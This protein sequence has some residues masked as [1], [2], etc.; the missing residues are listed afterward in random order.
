MDPYY[1]MLDDPL[2][3]LYSDWGQ[4]LL[5]ALAKEN[6][7]IP[8][9][10]MTRID[11]LK[12]QH[13]EVLTK[14]NVNIFLGVETCS[15]KMLEIMQ[16]TKNP[17]MYLNKI[18]EN[19]PLINERRIFATLSFILNHPGD[20]EVIL[21]E[22]IGFLENTYSRV[23]HVSTD[24]IHQEF[25]YLPGTVV[26]ENLQYYEREFGTVIKHKTW[27]KEHGNHMLLSRDVIPG[28]DALQEV[29][30]RLKWVPFLEKILNNRKIDQKSF[31][32][33]LWLRSHRQNEGNVAYA[34]SGQ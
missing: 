6:F 12:E 11:L 2:F 24:F 7:R 26:S 19:L 16:K 15:Q 31:L 27:W 23:P 30:W 3:P 22:T 20:S 10:F 34:L 13:L 5:T 21:N 25:V 14:L 33:Q 4:E 8:L 1:L 9:N 28:R 18:A 29:D 17:Q 32:L